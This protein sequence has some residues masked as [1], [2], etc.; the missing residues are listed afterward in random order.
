MRTLTDLFVNHD[1]FTDAGVGMVVADADGRIVHANE[2]AARVYARTSAAKVIGR[3]LRDVLPKRA[4]D[5]R[6]AIAQQ[7]LSTG[8]PAAV[9]DLWSGLALRAIVRPLAP[10]AR[11]PKPTAVAVVRRECEIGEAI[12]APGDEAAPAVR[13]VCTAEWD[14][15]LFKTLSARELEVLALIGEGFSN[16]QI[17]ERMHR[18]V[19]TVEFHRG[20]ISQKT[21]IDNRVKLAIMA[22]QARLYERLWSNQAWAG[23]RPGVAW[24]NGTGKSNDAETPPTSN[25]AN[26]V[27]AVGHAVL[28]GALRSS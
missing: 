23:A 17:A 19:K 10:C 20:T 21:G 15:G 22:Q 18:T 3:S 28:P 16:A 5:E 1:L 11:S 25:G 24:A 6:I 12:T 14:L 27:S 8:Q 13:V 2:V 26:G 7:V 9:Y 4:A